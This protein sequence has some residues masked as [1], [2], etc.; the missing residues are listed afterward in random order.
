MS[1]GNLD[2]LYGQYSPLLMECKNMQATG[3]K[4]P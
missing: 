3:Y 1:T 2:V 4:F